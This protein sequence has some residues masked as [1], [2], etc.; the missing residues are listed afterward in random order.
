[1]GIK[2]NISKAKSS[3][4][5]SLKRKILSHKKLRKMT[6][7]FRTYVLHPNDREQ[8]K[9]FGNEN[10]DKTIYIIRYPSNNGSGVMS[11]FFLTLQQIDIAEREGYIP[12]VDMKNSKT[13][14]YN[15]KDNAWEIWFSQPDIVSLESAYMSRNV[16]LSGFSK[17]QREIPD[18]WK[19]TIVEENDPDGSFRMNPE[20]I[21]YIHTLIEKHVSFGES[22]LKLVNLGEEMVNP[23]GCIGVLARGTDYTIL[24]PPG[25]LVQ[26]S[27]D[28]IV[29]KINEYDELYGKKDIFLVTEDFTIF[30]YFEEKFGNRLKRVSF[31]I[32]V[33]DYDGRDY[34]SRTG[35]FKDPIS[36]CSVYI[37]KL[38][39]LSK[40]RYFIGGLTSGTK[41][42]FV[43]NN[44][45]YEDSFVFYLG[46]Y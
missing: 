5:F 23:E 37:A 30:T 27:P 7:Y 8:K 18:I 46:Q 31:D 35:A 1:M 16:I 33:K 20:F 19:K 9:S 32:L 28:Q 29:K 34:L 24:Q 11:L 41:L 40:C 39:L 44:N 12:V 14:Y 36:S 17:K 22:I 42:S 26:P 21:N 6:N 25:E 43:M 13:Q 15:G 4:F 38:L 45:Q 3:L 2:Y 10:P